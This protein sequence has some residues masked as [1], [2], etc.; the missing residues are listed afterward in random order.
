[1]KPWQTETALIQFGRFAEGAKEKMGNKLYVGHLP[2]SANDDSLREMF[3]QAGQVDSAKVITDRDTGR[4]K[5]FGFVE[6]STDQEAADA[7]QKFNGAEYGGRNMT[8]AE[9][10]PMAPREERGGHR[11]GD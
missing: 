5:G 1:M 11:G 3:A 4:S 7:I 9:A 10:R 6:M 2:F 8:V